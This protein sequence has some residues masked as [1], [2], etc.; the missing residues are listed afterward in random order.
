MPWLSIVGST[1]SVGTRML[2]KK[3]KPGADGEVGSMER[4][5]SV[6][7]ENIAA[8]VEGSLMFVR[9]D[10][11]GTSGHVSDCHLLEIFA[12]PASSRANNDGLLSQSRDGPSDR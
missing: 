6:D 10:L 7:D 3:E 8:E 2:P 4:S 11:V 9:Y 1:L 12:R 5:G